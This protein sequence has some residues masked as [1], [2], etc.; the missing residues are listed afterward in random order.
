MMSDQLRQVIV[1]SISAD[2]IMNYNF[3]N[4]SALVFQEIKTETTSVMPAI[5]LLFFTFESTWVKGLRT[6]FCI[7][8]STIESTCEP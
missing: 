1:S 6:N 3:E 8:K 4:G 2:E 7:D 5:M